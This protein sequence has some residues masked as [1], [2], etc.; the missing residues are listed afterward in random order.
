MNIFVTDSCP[1]QSAQVLDDSR[2]NKMLLESVQ[3]ME[4]TIYE[5]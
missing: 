1:I 5:I 3:L 4:F 2:L